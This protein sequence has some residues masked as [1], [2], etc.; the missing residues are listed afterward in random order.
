MAT[1]QRLTDRYTTAFHGDAVLGH[2]AALKQ[3]FNVALREALTE[4]F[5]DA[6]LLIAVA[7]FAVAVLAPLM[8][9]VAPPK[10]PLRRR[11]LK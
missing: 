6:F 10:A 5:S 9:T 3:L 11:P 1:L 7:L 8:K 4:T 2:T